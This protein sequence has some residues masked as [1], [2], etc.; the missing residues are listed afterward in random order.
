[1]IVVVCEPSRKIAAPFPPIPPPYTAAP[2]LFREPIPSM[3]F[4]ECRLGLFK[5]QQLNV[6]PSCLATNTVNASAERADKALETVG[7]LNRDG[8]FGG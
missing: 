1:M 5:S 6:F 8:L 4:A 2:L 7:V 3:N